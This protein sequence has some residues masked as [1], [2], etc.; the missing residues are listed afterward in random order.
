MGEPSTQSAIAM[1]DERECIMSRKTREESERTLAECR[2]ELVAQRERRPARRINVASGLA[3]SSSCQNRE[4][5]LSQFTRL[6]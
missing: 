6:L 5:L 4:L 1:S 2:E 3:S